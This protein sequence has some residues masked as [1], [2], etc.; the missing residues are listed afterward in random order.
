MG[1]KGRYVV[2]TLQEGSWT[3][4]ELF[5]N[6]EEAKQHVRAVLAHESADARMRVVRLVSPTYRKEIRTIEKIVEE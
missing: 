1:R 4:G 3:D 2:Q 5:T 6:S